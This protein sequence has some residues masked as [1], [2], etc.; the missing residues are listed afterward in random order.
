MKTNAK[1]IIKLIAIGFFLCSSTLWGRFY[2]GIEGGY[3]RSESIFEY[4][5]KGSVGGFMEDMATHKENMMN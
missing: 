3:M 1:N 4:T 5:T 2:M